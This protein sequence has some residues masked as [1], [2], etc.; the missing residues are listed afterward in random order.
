MVSS[1]D[2][3][4]ALEVL[5]IG[6]GFAGLCAAI[7]LDA[8]GRSR[9]LVVDK[10]HGLGGTWWHNRYPG[11][12]CDIA[13]HLYCYSFEPN[14]NWS[15]LFSP[16][17]EIQAYLEHCATKYEIRHRLRLGVEVQ[18]LAFDAASRIWRVSTDGDEIHARHIIN[19]TGGLHKPLVPHFNGAQKFAGVQMHTAQWRDEV[20]LKGKRIAVIG[21]AASAIQVIPALAREAH[22]VTIFQR[23]PNYIA[24]RRDYA[25]SA[26][27]KRR[28]QQRPRWAQLY[29]QLLFLRGELLLWPVIKHKRFR[30]KVTKAI[31]KYLHTK[32]DEP[33]L[34]ARLQ[35]D[36][37]LGCK[38]ILVSD[39]Y[40]DALRK[41]NVE[42]VT[43]PIE[44]FDQTRLHTRDGNTYDADIVVYATGFDLPGHWHSIDVTGAHGQRLRDVWSAHA[45][46]Y[47]G[48]MV[49]GFPN[50]YMTTGP[51]TGVG[52]TSIVY[53]IEHAVRYI[54]RCIEQAGPH[55][56]VDVTQGAQST[57]NHQ[58]NA[59][60]ATTVWATG[61]SSWYKREDGRIE[62]LF[63]RNARQWARLMQS[64][65]TDALTITK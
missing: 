20:E 2:A 8:A 28:F 14:P 27:Q 15:H 21:S 62:T 39:D 37:E 58:L 60:L 40:Y 16:Q 22:A 49:A 31:L 57:Y 6:A 43:D 24:P 65:D 48:V 10:A 36:Y 26:Q 41:P 19:A 18:A 7:E 17:A 12:T 11:A 54:L 30:Q 52:T 34:R 3:R 35:P 45:H 50:Y 55:G 5:I 44:R 56:T 13:S 25:Y 61:C 29:R 53:M 9:F 33:A 59:E 32:I 46:A 51:N 4:S 47:R 64:A 42:L 63:P 23:T 38:R 1:D